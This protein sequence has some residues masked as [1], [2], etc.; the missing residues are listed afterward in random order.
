MD[1]MHDRTLQTPLEGA[2]FC[3]QTF[4]FTPDRDHAMN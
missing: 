2:C 4:D 3:K 1:R